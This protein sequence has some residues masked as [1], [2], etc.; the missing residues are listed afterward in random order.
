MYAVFAKISS[1]DFN[2]RLIE[3]P[4]EQAAGHL[5]VKSSSQQRFPILHGNVGGQTPSWGGVGGCM[6]PIPENT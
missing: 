4:S 2:V 1:T 6:I 3:N 5:L